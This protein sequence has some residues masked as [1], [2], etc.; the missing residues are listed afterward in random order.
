M[1]LRRGLGMHYNRMWSFTKTIHEFRIAINV[2]KTF[3]GSA[4]SFGSSEEGSFKTVQTEKAANEAHKVLDAAN[5]NAPAEKIAEAVNAQSGCKDALEAEIA[6]RERTLKELKNLLATHEQALNATKTAHQALLSNAAAAAGTNMEEVEPP[7]TGK[8]DFGG[9][10]MH[11]MEGVG[12]N[13]MPW[14]QP[15]PQYPWNQPS[16]N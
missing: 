15:A 9:K 10:M 7:G 5:P 13:F 11:E 6:E 16:E 8:M 1:E 2:I 12:G 3:R 14:M 4:Y